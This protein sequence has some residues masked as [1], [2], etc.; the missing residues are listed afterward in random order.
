MTTRLLEIT[1]SEAV[2]I[3]RAAGVITGVKV[4][5]RVSRNGR[6]YSEKAM[7]D[8]SRL[9]EGCKVNVDHP[10]R[11]RPNAE[12][13]FM[14]GFGE[15][16]N[17]HREQG[18]VYADL[19][20]LKSHPAAAAVCEMAERFPRQFGLS[21]NADGSIRRDGEK[22]IVESVEAVISVDIVGRPATNEGLFE[23][24]ESDQ[25]DKNVK[26]TLR[27]LVE[28]AGGK[29]KSRLAKLIE[30]D[31]MAAMADAPV[32]VASEGSTE[33]QIKAAFRQ[34]V[35]AAFDDDSLDSKATLAKIKEILNA[36]DKLNGTESKPD[37]SAESGGDGGPMAESVQ[38]VLRRLEL[39]EAKEEARE[40]LE[41]EGITATPVRVKLLAEADPK[42]RDA[43]IE[44]FRTSG[45]AP[46]KTAFGG[47]TKPEKSEPLRESTGGGTTE[48]PKDLATFA[49]LA[50]SGL[51]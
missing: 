10:S 31:G 45:A 22:V 7:E 1:T 43:L 47:V 32:E 46:R 34:A 23:S 33:D 25:K 51:R 24:V 41:S 12:R 29:F 50:K 6:E 11:D 38:K 42:N 26:T 28:S 15:L 13:G 40:M 27:K 4:L 20:F 49:S 2:K 3:D 16:R 37:K 39:Y 36:Y 19:H 48:Y 44:E 17:V 21:H 8:A 9:Y 18:G 35:M 14:E 30:E 5:G